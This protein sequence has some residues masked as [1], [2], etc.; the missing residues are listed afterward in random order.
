MTNTAAP[1]PF[2][3]N[4]LYADEYEEG[5]EA[6][7]NQRPFTE[8]PYT[9]VRTPYYPHDPEAFHREYR[10][11]LDAWWA[12]WKTWLDERALGNNFKPHKT[13]KP[14]GTAE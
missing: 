6:A 5:Y 1:R 8:C 2:V 14:K 10:P 9:F 12:G 13:R 3:L 11:K 7:S 4:H